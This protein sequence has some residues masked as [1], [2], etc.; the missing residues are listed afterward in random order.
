MRRYIGITDEPLCEEGKKAL[1]E[2]FS[3]PLPQVVYTSS[4]KR[5]KETAHLLYPGMPVRVREGFN[6]CD[7]G[8]FENKNYKELSGDG[9]YQAWVDSGG[10]LP[11]PGGESRE[12]F[13]ERNLHAF[14]QATEE[15][16][17]EKIGMAAFVVHGGSIMSILGEYGFPKKAF[18]EWQV[19]NG[20]GFLVHLDE[21]AWRSGDRKL[22]DIRSIL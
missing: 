7:F 20:Q 21:T 14:L 2:G 10:M 3:Y 19:K 8:K 5:T 16:L 17:E 15:L 22:T 18:Y 11:F 9:E 6:E 13:T 4:L 12:Q 1:L